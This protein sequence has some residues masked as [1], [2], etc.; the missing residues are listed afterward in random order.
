MTVSTS[1]STK[2]EVSVEKLVYG[3]DG[4]ARLDGHIVLLPFVLPG[5]RISI[6]TEAAK[7][8]L[9]RGSVLDILQPA[10]ERVVPGCQYFGNCGGCHYQ[11]ADYRFQLQQKREILRETLRRLGKYEFNGE[12]SVVS[13]PAWEYRNRVQLHFENN[14]V[15]FRRAGSHQLCAIEHCPISSPVL[16]EVISKLNVAAKQPEWPSFLRSLEVFTNEKEVQLHVTDSTRPVAARFFQ[17][18]HTFLPALVPGAIEYT[19]AGHS[20]RISRE[21][22]FQVN[23]F[24]VDQLVEEVISETAGKTVVDLYSGVGLFAL[25]LTQ[26]FKKVYAV[27]RSAP[28]FRDLDWN[29]KEHSAIVTTLKTDAEVYLQQT[30]ETPDLVI[31]DPPRAGL[32]KAVTARLT[33]LGP[34]EIRLVSCD[35]AT[36]ARDLQTLVSV[37]RVQRLTLVDLFPQTYHFEVVARL[38]RI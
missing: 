35:P 21:A 5:E 10:A 6:Q 17:W 31:A 13:G 28:A 38:E 7:S 25:P 20:F 14:Q 36:L 19:A 22:F 32:G 16:N 11:H 29:L 37:Y 18:C 27:E 3:G 23:R 15:G 24:L 30:D 26:R 4:L 33:D 9:I 34:P 8:G 12:I 2:A 1:A